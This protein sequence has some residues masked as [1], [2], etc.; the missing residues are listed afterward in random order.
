MRGGRQMTSQWKCN[1]PVRL[2]EVQIADVYQGGCGSNA[3]GVECHA[4]LKP[5]LAVLAVPLD[6]ML[7]GAWALIAAQRCS[8][9]PSSGMLAVLTTS[10]AAA[11]ATKSTGFNP[12][13]GMLAVLTLLWVG[14]LSIGGS[15]NPSGGM[16]AVLTGP[17]GGGKTH[18]ALFQSLSRDAACSD[19]DGNASGTEFIEAFQSLSRDAACS[20]ALW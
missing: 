11:I 8:F 6:E 16:L 7:L 12:S 5:G 18:T 20:D 14:H 15:F 1:A 9:N 17:A 2:H 10:R 13:G 3:L 4:A 19:N